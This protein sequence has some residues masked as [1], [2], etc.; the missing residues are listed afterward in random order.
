MYLPWA[1]DGR[2]GPPVVTDG[3]SHPTMY[4]AH[5]TQARHAMQV[6]W[7]PAA[8]RMYSPQLVRP[9][10]RPLGRS[11]D[12][13]ERGED[14]GPKGGSWDPSIPSIPWP[15]GMGSIRGGLDESSIAMD[16]VCG[17]H[18]DSQYE[19]GISPHLRTLHEISPS[20][21]LPHEYLVQRYSSS[22]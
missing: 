15:D 11:A 19:L 21:F 6:A 9:L 5:H 4:P 7:V 17:R 14:E 2:L 12:A 18:T 8:V 13:R 10:R 20:S 16:G 1:V 22:H 3:P